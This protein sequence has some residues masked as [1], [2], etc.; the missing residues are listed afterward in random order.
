MKSFF[1]HKQLKYCQTKNTGWLQT[2]RAG[3]KL[4]LLLVFGFFLSPN[5]NAQTDGDPADWQNIIANGQYIKINSPRVDLINSS[6]DEALGSGAKDVNDF[7]LCH[8]S[9]GANDKTDI[10]NAV[11]VL[12][13]GNVVRFAA[14]RF[15]QNGD[16]EI[17]IWLLKG[18]LSTNP[19]NTFTGQHTNG[20]V[21][22]TSKFT[23]GG[24]KPTI[25]VRTWQNGILSTAIVPASGDAD[26]NFVERNVPA[27]FQPYQS[28]FGDPNV[29]PQNAFFEGELDLDDIPGVDACFTRFIFETSQ[30]QSNTE[31]LG[32]F[33]LGNFDTK[34][35]PPSVTNAEKCYDGIEAC[36][37]ASCGSNNGTLIY[38][39][40]PT[41]GNVV[42]SP[43]RTAVGL[44]TFWAACNNNGCESNRTEVTVRINPN[45]TVDGLVTIEPGVTQLSVGGNPVED[46]YIIKV[47][48]T[49]VAHLTASASSGTSPYTYAWTRVN[50]NDGTA[51]A[52][53]AA[54]SFTSN[55]SDGTFTINTIQGLANAYCFKVTVTDDK[56]CTS[57]DIVE[58]R[59]DQSGPLCGI[60]GPAT[61]CAG[62]NN[63]VYFL[64]GNNDN[65][66]DALDPDFTY[67]W[68]ITG[69]G[70]I[71]GA[72]KVDV[73]TVTV[74]AGAGAGSYTVS[75]NIVS[76]NGLIVITD[77]QHPCTA[78]TNVTLVE[79]SL[80]KS[81]ETCAGGDGTVTAT[82]SG[83]TAPYKI[84]INGGTY[85]DPATSPHVF[86]ALAAGLYTVHVVDA[87]GCEDSESITVGE[88]TN[89]GHGCTP[90][91]WKSPN[92]LTYWDS[93]SDPVA[94]AAGFYTGTN[95]FSFL[96]ITTYCTMSSS[97][98]MRQAIEM[99]GGGCKALARHGA[100]A[101]LNA[102]TL[103][104]YP[105]PA[106]VTTYQGLKD[107]IEAAFE[108]GCN[109]NALA[110]E[111]AANNDL[112]HE[113]CGQVLTNAI[114]QLSKVPV[115]VG[116]ED[117]AISAYP[118]PYTNMVNFRFTAPESGKA[119][120]EVYDIMGRK[121]AIVYQGMVKANVPVNAKYNVPS[122]SRVALYYKLTVNNKLAKGQVV[123][124]R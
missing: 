56:G 104:D 111:L 30:S 108:S 33:L 80:Q 20:D 97:M 40:A 109:C 102:A 74:T 86:Q 28:K 91:F 113:N 37:S 59:P 41:G 96:E 107:A 99:N 101:L 114:S 51:F 71:N 100:A 17:G 69:N 57:T 49:N 124:E 94:V 73:N 65:V 119:V 76:D 26:V 48:T 27:V 93:P 34:P 72:P 16:A 110:N 5:L 8:W 118:N 88:A 6:A 121:L 23:N 10:H 85:V 29:Y 44:S 38:Y 7:P 13:A 11:L 22:I 4:S 116:D 122:V 81:D 63:N 15:A 1:I 50:C 89:C 78:S 39:D 14:D 68:S 90:G 32:D 9:Y 60:D 19:D 66:A 120:L 2:F 77:A 24:V 103:P 45:P 117:L 36:A 43:C 58:I 53:D 62:S 84:Q 55:G 112:N 82:F 87:T 115:A 61:V 54:T 75:L 83:G 106:G 25:T 52:G 123:P 21:L 98:T 67:T 70:T 79:L 64:D 18:P 12:L 42:A 105:L 3:L 31:S 35:N 95:F 47:S 46:V 92:G